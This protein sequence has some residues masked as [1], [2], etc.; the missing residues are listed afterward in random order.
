[1]SVPRSIVMWLSGDEALDAELWQFDQEALQ[2]YVLYC[3]QHP[4]GGL[5]DK[6]GKWVL[7]CSL[8]S[9]IKVSVSL[10][11]PPPSFPLSL[12][13]SPPLFPFLS[14]ARDF[15]HTCYCLSGLS[16]AQHCYGNK[17][18]V[19]IT[20]DSDS[21]LVSSF[22]SVGPWRPFT[23]SLF[24]TQKPTHPAFNIVANRVQSAYEYFSQLASPHLLHE[25]KPKV[26]AKSGEE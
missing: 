4:H 13:F 22:V 9:H 2:E 14:R 7:Y 6:P 20:L 21:V 23:I 25:D 3:C 1:M 5:I 18:I 19:N 24:P 26:T 8:V 11:P 17:N 10:S 16:V 12:S 15:Y